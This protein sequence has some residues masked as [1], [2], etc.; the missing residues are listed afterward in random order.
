MQW[1]DRASR[2][3]WKAVMT[4]K[5]TPPK[6]NTTVDETTDDEKKQAAA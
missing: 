4:E 5:V 6:C 2:K 3:N 1:M